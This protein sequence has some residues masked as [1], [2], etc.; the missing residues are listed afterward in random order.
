MSVSVFESPSISAEADAFTTTLQ[1][2]KCNYGIYNSAV[3]KIYTTGVE[4]NVT[5]SY[6][7]SISS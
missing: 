1:S 5:T 3:S 7:S 2:L 4:V 6:S